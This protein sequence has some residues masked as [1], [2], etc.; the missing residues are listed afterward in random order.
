MHSTAI[1][2]NKLY[3]SYFKYNLNP[4]M[5]IF[6]FDRQRHAR[7]VELQWEEDFSKQ[8]FNNGNAKSLD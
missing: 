4:L 1:P 6:P 2:F 8:T 3:Y 7:T 5:V